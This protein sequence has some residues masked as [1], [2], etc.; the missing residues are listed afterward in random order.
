M[1]NRFAKILLF[2]AI[3][4]TITILC[5]IVIFQH[6]QTLLAQPSPKLYVTNGVASGDVTNSTAVIWARANIPSIMNVEYSIDKNLKNSQN[7]SMP[8]NKT[9]DFTGHVKLKNLT[10]NIQYFYRVWLST[11]DSIKGTITSNSVYGTFK[12]APSPASSPPILNFVIGGDLGGQGFCRKANSQYSIFSV[13]QSLNPDF[14]I[15]NGDQIYAD[16]FCSEKGPSDAFGWKNINESIPSITSKA[17]TNWSN[18]NTD[19]E[20]YQKHWQYNRNDPYLQKLLQNT[21]IYSQLD[22][23]EVINDYGGNWDHF[24]DYP[25]KSGFPTLVKAGTTAFFN[26]SPMDIKNNDNKNSNTDLTNIYRHFNWGKNL[27]LFLLDTRSYRSLNNLVD[28]PHNNKTLLGK[29]QL[30]W[31]E[32][33]LVDSNAT[34][35]I[36][37]TTVPITIPNCYN[38]TR[39]CDSWATDGTTNKT[40]TSERSEFLKFLDDNNINN[41]VFVT[42]DVHFPAN[43]KVDEDFN[44]DG[45]KLKFHEL[46]NGPLSAIPLGVGTRA[47][48]TINEILKYNESKIFNFGHITIQHHNPTT[49]KVSLSTEIIDNNGLIR[50]NSN[51]TLTAE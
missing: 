35:K 9:L 6:Y 48:P 10:S 37:S 31:L 51:I 4:L 45:D 40:F 5:I 36:I 38:S 1:M 12:T 43:I 29:E 33:G 14:F 39:G 18:Y 13:M 8:V 30:H 22:D 41:I 44:G 28:D 2:Y 11:P 19:Y 34:W 24:V 16:S 32:Q 50:P 46:V 49:G 21:S 17:S 27:D 3:A 20:I 47:D 7:L 23:H 42:T 26:Y 15:F 25:L